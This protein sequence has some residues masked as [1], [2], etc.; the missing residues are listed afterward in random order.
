MPAYE[1]KGY[2]DLIAG[3][4]VPIATTS[5]IIKSGVGT[6]LSRGTVLGVLDQNPDGTYI[7][8]PVD[9]KKAD[10][11]KSPFGILADQEVDASITDRRA[12]A[13]ITGEF[14]RDAL[15]FGGTDT[16][17]THDIALREIGILTKRVVK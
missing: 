8:A 15:K 6:V 2:D 16:I 1:M 5:V 3:M 17:T 12:T 11:P 7:V 4:V 10:G 14:N 13:Y 9:S